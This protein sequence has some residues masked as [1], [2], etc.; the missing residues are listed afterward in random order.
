MAELF[1]SA[2]DTFTTLL[3]VYTPVQNKKLK[4]IHPFLVWRDAELD[5]KPGFLIPNSDFLTVF[6]LTDALYRDFLSTYCVPN[7]EV[8]PRVWPE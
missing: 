8:G 2:S 7:T 6:G 1:C 3:I 4:T 5:L